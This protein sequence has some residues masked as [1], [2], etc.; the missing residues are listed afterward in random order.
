MPGT[1][2]KKFGRS[3]QA[4]RRLR[5]ARQQLHLTRQ[6]AGRKVGLTRVT[7]WRIE[8]GVTEAKH[9]HVVTLARLLGVSLDSLHE[10]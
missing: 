7:V 1:P 10:D 8:E 4:G 2:A 3:E 5:E 9:A 6:A